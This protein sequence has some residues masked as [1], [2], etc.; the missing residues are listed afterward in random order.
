[1]ANPAGAAGGCGP[2][3]DSAAR[4]GTLRLKVEGNPRKERDVMQIGAFSA[5]KRAK[6]R[7]HP[8]ASYAAHSMQ[9]H[10]IRLNYI[11]W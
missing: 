2:A 11:G 7:G 5:D 10:G 8:A 4:A 3:I 1:M 9:L 6:A